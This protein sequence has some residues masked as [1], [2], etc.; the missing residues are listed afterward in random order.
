[1][2]LL[3]V[4]PAFAWLLGGRVGSRPDRLAGS[5]T[6]HPGPKPEIQISAK[7]VE[8][9]QGALQQASGQF[10]STVVL[11]A[12]RGSSN[13]PLNPLGSQSYAGASQ[14]TTNTTTYKVA[15]NNPLR[16]GIVLVPSISATS[17]FGTAND[18]NNLPWQNQGNVNFSIIVP[19]RKGSGPAAAAAELAASLQ[20]Q[21]SNKDLRFTIS[22]SVLNTVTAYW[23]LVAASKNHIGRSTKST[24]CLQRSLGR[25]I[26]S[27]IV[28]RED[29]SGRTRRIPAI[30]YRWR[31]SATGV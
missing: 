23:N 19:L 28:L 12:D 9:S 16:N 14:L 22:Q 15:L 31:S 27:H 2:E 1:M 24:C 13:T 5:G 29:T 6:H 18:L 17:T 10:A 21:A 20:L 30:F 25:S 7:Q 26:G 11:S 8:I 4:W 3:R